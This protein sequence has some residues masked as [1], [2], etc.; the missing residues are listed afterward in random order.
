MLVQRGRRE[1]DDPT[2]ARRYS[3]DRGCI[4]VGQGLENREHDTVRD[5]R[6][7]QRRA[8]LRGRPGRQLTLEFPD[9]ALALRKS[10]GIRR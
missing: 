3:R 9:N 8:P 5:T 4:H 7:V 6:L 2:D 10:A 1:A